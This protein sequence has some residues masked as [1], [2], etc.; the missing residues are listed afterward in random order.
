MTG[1]LYTADCCM[2]TGL[3]SFANN[4]SQALCFRP[5]A[6][7]IQ[8]EPSRGRSRP[9]DVKLPY[10][11]NAERALCPATRLSRLH[12]LNHCHP[13]RPP[14]PP[15]VCEI[16]PNAMARWH[17]RPSRTMSSLH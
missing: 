7:E 14:T 15:G 3:R 13:Q 1:A 5:S 6:L 12:I 17:H 2:F 10:C 8:C 11:T 4:G 9:P 16:H